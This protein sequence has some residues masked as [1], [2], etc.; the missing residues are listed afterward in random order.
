[1]KEE[2]ERTG[3]AELTQLQARFAALD[4]DDDLDAEYLSELLMVADIRLK[5]ARWATRGFVCLGLEVLFVILFLA[6]SG[7]VA[8]HMVGAATTRAANPAIRWEVIEGRY[9]RSL[10][11][12]D[13]VVVSRPNAQIRVQ[14]KDSS[15]E[16]SFKLIRNATYGCP[17]RGG[18]H[19]FR[20]A[21]PT[22]Q[23]ARMFGAQRAALV[24]RISLQEFSCPTG[25]HPSE[26]NWRLEAALRSESGPLTSGT[27]RLQT[28]AVPQ[29]TPAKAG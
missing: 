17:E 29:H 16:H 24:E 2:Q 15:G 22:V 26:V 19:R 7:A 25:R 23:N 9:R 1:M 14:A 4:N 12:V 3:A 10:A 6:T 21:I 5:E 28:G 27:L 8:G 13:S 20:R 11:A 18:A